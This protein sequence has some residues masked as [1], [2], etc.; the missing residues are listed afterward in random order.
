MFLGRWASSLR[1][2][3]AAR[4]AGS[5][6]CQQRFHITIGPSVESPLLRPFSSSSSLFKKNADVVDVDPQPQKEY[7]NTM[8]NN[9][10]AAVA[11]EDEEVL[12]SDDQSVAKSFPVRALAGCWDSE[13]AHDAFFGGHRPLLSNSAFPNGVGA[14]LSRPVGGYQGHYYKA[15]VVFV[16]E[17][18]ELAEE[19]K[20]IQNKNPNESTTNVEVDILGRSIVPG[21][22]VFSSWAEYARYHDEYAKIFNTFAPFS[23]PAIVELSSSHQNAVDSAPA[24]Q[25]PATASQPPNYAPLPV[26]EEEFS[27]LLVSSDRQHIQLDSPKAS[28]ERMHAISIQKRRKKKMNK[29]KWKKRRKAVR[30]STRYNPERRKKGG[31]VREKQ[32]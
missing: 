9:G 7:D 6:L 4:H 30:D 24:T 31:I 22:R 27:I 3:P 25:Q 16:K 17:V 20:S 18:H 15:A 5:Q 32:E 23:P 28:N 21:E 29:H 14:E 19:S 12:C 10:A 8:T 13:E 2:V 1:A 11:A 26:S